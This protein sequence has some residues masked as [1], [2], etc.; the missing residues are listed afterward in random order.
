MY[1]YYLCGHEGRVPGPTTLQGI[2]L[3]ILLYHNVTV[4]YKQ[5]GT[6]P[7]L[8]HVR[9]RYKCIDN[10]AW[11]NRRILLQHC[12]YHNSIIGTGY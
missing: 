3:V 1:V 2:V 10:A 11:P 4:P 12:Q 8:F 5:M 6:D 9:C 7:G